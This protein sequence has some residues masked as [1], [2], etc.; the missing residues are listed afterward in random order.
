MNPN[1]L[2]IGVLS[3]TPV[4]PV[5]SNPAR[6]SSKNDGFDGFEQEN[7]KITSETELFS[8]KWGQKSPAEG[9]GN[10]NGVQP[11]YNISFRT[12][13]SNKGTQNDDFGNIFNRQLRPNE[14]SGESGNVQVATKPQ[15][16]GIADNSGQVQPLI[17]LQKGTAALVEQKQT[18][19][20]SKPATNQANMTLKPTVAQT[21]EQSPQNTQFVSLV[22]Q[23]KNAQKEA[24]QQTA[25]PSNQTKPVQRVSPT[26]ADGT[27]VQKS[28][29][30][31]Q[32]AGTRGASA[33]INQTPR[34]TVTI[35]TSS[36][37]DAGLGK[38]LESVNQR[39]PGGDTG[40][41]DSKAPRPALSDVVGFIP[42]TS[43]RAGPGVK[44]LDTSAPVRL[45]AYI[46]KDAVSE[47]QQQIPAKGQTRESKS[48]NN[49]RIKD[50]PLKDQQKASSPGDRQEVARLSER[51]NVE[52]AEL[53][54]GNSNTTK[55][56][57][58]GDTAQ[59]PTGRVAIFDAGGIV[60][61]ASPI[62][63]GRA[64]TASANVPVQ[65][66]VASVREQIYQSVKTSVQQGASQITIR[67]N[68]PEL[69]Q[70]SIKFSEQGKELTGILEATNPQTRAEIRQAIPEII[71]SLEESGISIKRLDVILSSDSPRQPAQQSLRD[72]TS[73]D[74]WEQF[75]QPDSQ[76]SRGG[77]GFRDN[78]GNRPAQDSYITPAYSENP[79]A[80]GND[81]HAFASFGR[82]QALPSDNLLDVLI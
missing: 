73:G 61:N 26:T 12:P 32:I 7:N 82:N 53:L 37:G 38:P 8:K 6:N 54:S 34:N 17:Q 81:V 28:E 19:P 66:N 5:R 22:N 48:A 23:G 71:R 69:G 60:A 51:T 10:L 35:K 15:K 52:K 33:D 43:L 70:V 27:S 80:P 40:S 41:V 39:K 79:G 29:G 68:P 25:I 2:T 11:S 62:I 18:N 47:V 44:N 3:A 57:F 55:S 64:A 14:S 1:L 21:S 16:S 13:K 56:E 72:N 78:P 75:N 65:D 59:S 36:V 31:K 76:A 74:L 45:G 63:A 67:L 20:D 49:D 4:Q 9:I 46:G 50:K 58:A 24:L 77:Q 42:S 30:D